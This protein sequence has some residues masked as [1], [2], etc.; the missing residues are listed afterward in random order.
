MSDVRTCS[1]CGKE[2]DADSIKS[3]CYDCRKVD[4]HLF[5]IIR[6][7]L[8]D[9]PGAS[10]N[11]VVEHTGVTSSV[12]LKYLREGRLETVGEIKLLNC[13]ICGKPISY[14]TKCTDCQH[15]MDHSFQ[16]VANV[17]ERNTKQ[18]MYTTTKKK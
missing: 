6:D 7:F 3:L 17:K 10:V 2:F 13:E 11:D 18:K 14:G 15:K 1:I 12:V 16:A 5:G 9:N 8:Y 4:R